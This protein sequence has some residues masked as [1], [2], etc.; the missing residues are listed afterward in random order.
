MDGEYENQKD[1]NQHTKQIYCVVENVGIKSKYHHPSELSSNYEEDSDKVQQNRFGRVLKNFKE[2]LKRGKLTFWKHKVKEQN[3]HR[4]TRN[5]GNNVNTPSVPEQVDSVENGEI[6]SNVEDIND[7]V[8]LDKQSEAYKK[9][10][11]C[12]FYWGPISSR[13][14][15]QE[16][17]NK[18]DGTFIIRDSCSARHVY[19]LSFRSWGRTLHTRIDFD[20]GYFKI[21]RQEGYSTINLMLEAVMQLSKNGVYCFTQSKSALNPSYPVRLLSPLSRFTKISSLKHMCRFVIREHIN[22]NDI[23]NLQLPETVKS[24]LMEPY[25]K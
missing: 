4:V 13:E 11:K 3:H 6:E 20:N 25:F 19:S 12:K 8:V 7:D 16:L 22:I 15:E 9:L 23:N 21:F 2:K 1:P 5:L 17:R 24:Y 10:H 14:A 18:P